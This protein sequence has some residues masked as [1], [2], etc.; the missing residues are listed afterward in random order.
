MYI[1]TSEEK[2]NNDEADKS[3]NAP[4]KNPQTYLHFCHK[5][6][7]NNRYNYKQIWHNSSN[8]DYSS[9][10]YLKKIKKQNYN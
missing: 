3:Y 9:K 10:C 6:S 4:A 1:N 5:I 7:K 2:P 8:A